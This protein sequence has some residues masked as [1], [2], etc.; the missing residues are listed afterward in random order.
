RHED[1]IAHFERSAQLSETSFGALSFMAQIYQTLG[2]DEEAR[3]AA[4]RGLERIERE[5]LAHP[6]NALAMSFAVG[7]LVQL[8]QKERAREWI[9]RTL[10][11]EPDDVVIRF[12]LACCLAQMGEAEEALDLLESSVCRMAAIVGWIKN[13]PDLA[14]LRGH[15][16][17][18]ALVTRKT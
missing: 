8:G 12:N 7:L 14:P 9:S 2:R 15:P 11:V 18:Q 17:Y 16:R 4:R 10:I 5:V 1:A 13:D 6:D 3:H